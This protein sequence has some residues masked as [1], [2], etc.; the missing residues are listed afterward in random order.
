MAFIYNSQQLHSIREN[1]KNLT[2]LNSVKISNNS[3]KKITRIIQ[4]GKTIK[5]M[6]TP[7]KSSEIKKIKN[8]IFI[9][10]LFE[11]HKFVTTKR[12]KRFRTRK[13]RN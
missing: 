2:K 3:G 13:Q 10:K 11:D 5:N 1:N 8:N 6:V 12:S 9:P 7:L 4:N